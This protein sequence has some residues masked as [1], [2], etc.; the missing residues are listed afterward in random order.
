MSNSNN[1]KK[2]YHATNLVQKS[3]LYNI[4]S[5]TTQKSLTNKF[6]ISLSKLNNTSTKEIGFNEMKNLI[7]Y[8]KTTPTA[9]RSY[10]SVLNSYNNKSTNLSHSAKELQ[11]LLYGFIAKVYGDSLYDTLDTPPNIIKTINRM[12]SQLRNH[13]LN[14]S[15]I[16]IHKACA[17]SYKE[18]L[19]YSMPKD[20]HQLIISVFFDPIIDLISTGQSKLIQ[21]G[22][23]IIL[24]E[25]IDVIGL[26]DCGEETKVILDQVS[27]K[28]VQYLTKGAISDNFYTIDALYKL[29]CFV[30]FEAFA[31]NLQEIYDKLINIIKLSSINY[32]G[33]ISVL[34]VFGLIADKVSCVEDI[35]IGCYQTNVYN[36]IKDMTTD[37]VHKVQVCAKEV[38]RKWDIIK[39]MVDNDK[40][41]HFIYNDD[42]D[43]EIGSVNI[44]TNN[45]Y[46]KQK[47]EEKKVNDPFKYAYLDDRD[48]N[49][50]QTIQKEKAKL[51]LNIN[52]N[53][54][55][56]NNLH[57]RNNFQLNNNFKLG[58]VDRYK[59]LLTNSSISEK[60][61]NTDIQNI[62]EITN[63][64][65]NK[66][67]SP[68]LTSI[69]KLTLSNLIKNVYEPKQ[70]QLFSEI[71]SHLINL[72]VR[73]E[74]LQYKVNSL[75]ITQNLDKYSSNDLSN[76]AVINNHPIQKN[77]S[78][79]FSF[80]DIQQSSI[81][82]NRNGT[83]FWK[84]CLSFLEKNQIQRAYEEIL[85]SGDDI[86]L[87]RLVCLTGPVL[88]SLDIETA[89]KVLKRINMINRSCQIQKVLLNLVEEGVYTNKE[90]FDGLSHQDKNDI[91]DSLYIIGKSDLNDNPVSNKANN[92]YNS[93]IGMSN[94]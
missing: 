64:N 26:G 23:A 14:E 39:H 70:E 37:R 92:L 91:L 68:P 15:N 29:M 89:R 66:K 12:L 52:Q 4:N 20:N 13:Y 43:N 11:C 79:N 51:N 24:C 86:Y 55:N 30:D 93:I 56:D 84:R 80:K 75:P 44:N 32:Q 87:L 83:E 34:N 47:K 71:N 54:N 60:N 10:L 61:D 16:T 62:I 19:I 67:D 7:S 1:S 88:N 22:A 48:Y 58:N 63:I 27:G 53:T 65:N 8:N 5:I 33:K 28:M 57:D 76:I 74:N 50:R 41:G 85:N 18:L 45:K 35:A 21:Q 42:N 77:L 69:L 40:K 81:Y 82:D 94:I 6:Q 9:L 72:E 31:Y 73:I 36:T 3:E 59:N 46:L 2:K 49:I 78:N 25:L 17:N 38:C 90:I